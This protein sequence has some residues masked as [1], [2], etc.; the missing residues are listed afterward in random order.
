MGVVLARGTFERWPAATFP[1]EALVV[2]KLP[3]IERGVARQALDARHD[4][5]GIAA[6][7]RVVDLQRCALK[8]RVSRD[9]DK[10][11]GVGFRINAHE[12]HDVGVLVDLGMVGFLTRVERRALARVG[13]NEQGIERLGRRDSLDGDAVGLNLPGCVVQ[14]RHQPN[15]R[16]R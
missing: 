12:R 14:E 2:A 8:H 10:R 1:F 16:K 3:R 9:A 15:E 4:L 13:A 11:D 7:Q 6:Q 5:L